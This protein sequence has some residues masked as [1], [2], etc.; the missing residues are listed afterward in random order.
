[1]FFVSPEVPVEMLVHCTRPILA[2]G[3]VLVEGAVV[4]PG[5]SIGRS[6][7]TGGSPRAIFAFGSVVEVLGTWRRGSLRRGDAASRGRAF[8]NGPASFSRKRR[9]EVHERHS[10]NV[11]H[12]GD[13]MGAGRRR[14]KMWT[15]RGLRFRS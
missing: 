7:W 13:T 5:D 12:S 3:V 8:E 4:P 2:R 1:M 11:V 9:Q 15:R 10:V 6:S 14:G